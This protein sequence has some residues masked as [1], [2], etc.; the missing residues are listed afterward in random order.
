[1]ISNTQL[2]CSTNNLLSYLTDLH[3]FLADKCTSRPFCVRYSLELTGYLS[4][5]SLCWTWIRFDRC[6]WENA[7]PMLRYGDRFRLIRKNLH[8][9]IGTRGAMRKFDSL[10]DVET[11]RF[12]LRV[13]RSPSDLADHIRKYVPLLFIPLSFPFLFSLFCFPFLSSPPFVAFNVFLFSIFRTELN[14]ICVLNR[15]TGAIIL[16]ISHGYTIEPENPDPLVDLADGVLVEFSLSAQPGA[17]LVDVLPFRKSTS[18]T[19]FFSSFLPFS[20]F[21]FLK[22]LSLPCFT[23]KHLT[24][25]NL[26]YSLYIHSTLY[27][28]DY[29][30]PLSIPKCFPLL[31]HFYYYY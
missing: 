1:M 9:V 7:L 18:P 19:N 14:R 10:L 6:G 4:F 2:T 30:L 20:S 26:N 17:W 16:S 22:Y 25:L 3:S 23:T 31:I 5:I 11:R 15:T 13:L 29:Y 27:T 8:Q 24:Y 21:Y 28:N 12:L